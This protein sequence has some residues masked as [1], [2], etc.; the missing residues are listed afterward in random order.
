MSIATRLASGGRINRQQRADFEFD[1]KRIPAY[2]GDTVASALL[3]AGERVVAR[4]FKYHRPRGIM[5]AG[6]E[7]SNALLTVGEGG[8]AE[9]N[10]PATTLEAHSSVKVFGQNAWPSVRLDWRAINGWFSPLF[11]AGF[12]YKTFQWPNWHLFEPTIRNMAGMS[13]APQGADP[14]RYDERIGELL[15]KFEQKVKEIGMDM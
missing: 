5:A 9:P 12:Y 6:V 10:L 15:N 4:S 3:A 7:E 1:G 2:A 11:S 13:K 14:D 8:K